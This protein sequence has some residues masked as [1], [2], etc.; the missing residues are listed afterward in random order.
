MTIGALTT[1]PPVL[2]QSDL[3]PMPADS[4]LPVAG[5]DAILAGLSVDAGA[6]DAGSCAATCR[7][8]ETPSYSHFPE[9]PDA[10][11]GT[12]ESPVAK[13]PDFAVDPVPGAATHAA[14]V[15]SVSTPAP[16]LPAASHSLAPS[17]SRTKLS[18]E[19][20]IETPRP[21]VAAKIVAPF[22]PET[23]F[24]PAIAPASAEV[25]AAV[26]TMAPGVAKPAAPLVP[27]GE[28]IETV[29][30]PATPTTFGVISVPAN[31][32]R[33]IE[34]RYGRAQVFNELGLFQPATP[35]PT[36]PAVARQPD[37]VPVGTAAD[38]ESAIFPVAPSKALPLA[39]SAQNYAAEPARARAGDVRPSL[40]DRRDP[41]SRVSAIDTIASNDLSPRPAG[42]IGTPVR[43]VAPTVRD[44]GTAEPA[45]PAAVPPPHAEATTATHVS[46]DA[47]EQGLRVIASTDRLDRVERLRLRDRIAAV[48]S[49]HGFVPA[50]VRLGGFTNGTESR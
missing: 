1:A 21:P 4:R 13:T 22:K 14:A 19:V 16:Y 34:A 45:P 3:G 25:F 43:R 41:A 5:F 10:R 49:R 31:D 9:Q 27:S 12:P 30:A 38:P 47:V 33:T 29:L 37:L 8:F 28:T 44:A 36:L 11:D 50:D 32:S 35:S 26:G 40:P 42:T 39:I 7:D 15:A 24:E 2:M 46:L 18:V 20:R 6:Y 23:A 48:L 17:V